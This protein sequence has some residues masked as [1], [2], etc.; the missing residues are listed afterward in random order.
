MPVLFKYLNA[1]GSF[2]LSAALYERCS[3]YIGKP[4]FKRAID[5]IDEM[6]ELTPIHNPEAAA[7]AYACAA[8]IA[9]SAT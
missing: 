4:T 1:D 5:F 2:D 8:S 6:E 9:R 3:A 7:I